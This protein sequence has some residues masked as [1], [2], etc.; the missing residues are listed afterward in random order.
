[1]KEGCIFCKIV[2][3]E[4]S[5]EMIYEDDKSIVFKDINPQAPVH[6]LVVPKT[7]IEASTD[8]FTSY[9]AELLGSLFFAA[10][11]A[12]EISGVKNTG[13]RLIIN[14]GPDSGQE[15][16][17]LHIHLLGGKKLGRLVGD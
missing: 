12:A 15:V 7:H 6:L 11:K 8:G 17:H 10:E 14:T 13:F 16:P 9:D 3:G 2:Q 5:A 4:I 1:M